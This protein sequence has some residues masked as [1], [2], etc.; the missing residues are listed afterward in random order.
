MTDA[1]ISPFRI[2]IPQADLDAL[3]DRLDNTRWPDE[4]PGVGWTYGV[5]VSYLKGLAEYWRNSY[6]WRT[7][8][9]KLNDF[10]QFTTEIDGQNIHFLHVRSPEPNALPLILTHGWPG[11]IVEFMNV[12]GPLTDPC[13]YGGDPADAFHVVI[14]SMP[15][16]GFSGPTRETGW[17]MARIAHAWAELMRRLGYERYGAQ[18]G[19][20]G[21][22][23]SPML[24]GIDPQRV[25]GVHVNGSLGFPTGDP[26][27]MAAMSEAELARLGALQSQMTDGTGYAII[28]STRPRT[29]GF[30]LADSPVGQLAWIVEKFKEWT[31]P[32]FELPEDA[33]DRD[34][35]LTN[36]SVY[37]LTNTA[38]SAARLYR[39]GQASWGQ[40]AERSEVQSGF[41][42]FPGDF[43]IRPIAERDNNVVH[44]SE[45]ER[46]GHFPAL[47]VPDLL[48]GD[49]R[50][51]FR[52]VR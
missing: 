35:M 14:P 52:G 37:W 33:V 15:G 21:S 48:V 40:P 23:I 3:N 32:A 50:T 27:E 49:V 16:F 10:P 4:L 36:V 2:Q 24:G 47:E 5:P 34:L 30:G 13:A 19:D 11:S 22:V 42:V 9:A 41:A 31:D 17:D 51:F 29:L 25:V 46:G 28:Q 18:G 45:F 43:G 44:W 7:F 26:A 39:E 38:T 6:D 8:E 12:I 1:L 20:A